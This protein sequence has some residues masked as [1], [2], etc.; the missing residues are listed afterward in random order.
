MKKKTLVFKKY[1]AAAGVITAIAFL[2]VLWL[3]FSPYGLRKYLAVRADGERTAAE[4][5]ALRRENAKI[6]Q[7]IE[8]INTDKAYLEEVARRQG[9]LRKN[10]IVFDFSRGRRR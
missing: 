1:R 4:I 10:E 3:Y 5:A 8:K 6:E 9:L 2:L 7:Q